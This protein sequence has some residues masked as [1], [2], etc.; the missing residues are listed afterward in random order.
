MSIAIY[1]RYILFSM[2]IVE[3]VRMADMVFHIMFPSAISSPSH[4]HG[5]HIQERDGYA[6]SCILDARTRSSL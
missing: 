4:L 2:N 3:E 1:P 6:D 5:L